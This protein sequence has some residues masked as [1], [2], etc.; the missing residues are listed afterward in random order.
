[1]RAVTSLAHRLT[2]PAVLAFAAGALAAEAPPADPTLPPGALV[3]LGSTRLRP[4]GPVQDLAFSPDGKWLA[5]AGNGRHVQVWDVATGTERRRLA[6][7][8]GPVPGVGLS[9]L[10]LVRFTAGGDTLVVADNLGTVRFLDPVAGTERGRLVSVGAVTDVSLSADGKLAAVVGD[11]AVSLW[12]LPGRTL[13][14]KIPATAGRGRAALTPDGKLLV[15]IGTD[16]SAHVID[17]DTGRQVRTLTPPAD[18]G[19]RFFRPQ[20]LAVA[21]DGGQVALGSWDHQ[22]IVLSLR[23][24]KPVSS[25]QGNAFGVMSLAYA[26]SGRFLAVGTHPG[27]RLYGLASGAE[28]RQL[29]APTPVACN[30]LAFS[31]DGRLLA[32]V[33]QNAVHLWELDSARERFPAE[34]HQGVVSALA[35]LRDGRL[36][37]QGSDARLIAW[38]LAAGRELASTRGLQLPPGE[39]ATTADG[40]GV[41]AFGFDRQ[42][43]VWRPGSPPETRRVSFPAVDHYQLALSPDGRRGACVSA[44]DR[45]LRLFE[46]GGKD[47]TVRVLPLPVG[48]WV[49]R[50]VFS[51]DG[52]RLATQSSDGLLRLWNCETGR[53]L[54]VGVESPGAPRWAARL[55][56]A[57][58]GRRLL[59]QDTE[60]WVAE[61]VSGQR[62]ARLPQP[63][64][65]TTAL[66]F[67]P[68]GRLVAWGGPSGEVRL[69]TADTGEEVAVRQRVGP[70]HDGKPSA[71]PV[72]LHDERQGPVQSVAFSPDGRLLAAGGSS[73]LIVVWKVPAPRTHATIA[74]DRREA[75]WADLGGPDP[76]RAGRAVAELV[77]APGPAVELLGERLRTPAPGVDPKRLER[78]V[79][80]LDNDAFEVREKAQRELA[81]AGAA[82]EGVLRQA[83]EKDPSAELR[84]RVG[85]LLAPLDQGGVPSG[86][87][88]GVRAVEVLERLGTPAARALLEELAGKTGDEVVEQE[89]RDGL[90]RLAARK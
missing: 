42:L 49:N 79:A 32:G 70:A 37:S 59:L 9:A 48:A 77:A 43:H 20:V 73:G 62:R 56:F 76:E 63:A 46:P 41:Q 26:P 23:T 15:L 58:D 74:R 35:F 61:A 34:G 17:C 12:G 86:R 5:T 44:S 21:P 10:S 4:D 66:A 60:L 36:V 83:L 87:L 68:D 25:V 47:G 65:Q 6:L 31:P 51:P 88:R 28:L 16:Q 11:A 18:P 19:R 53:E 54:R 33:A 57:A 67:S 2:L 69:F 80:D 52:S 81:A 27:V 13:R 39:L 22:L 8:G 29:E 90:R 89:V 50:L 24:G 3:R 85:E 71:L 14:H 30:A 55:L 7:D 82:A 78:L 40:G 1:M 45:K 64:A 75:L 38:D 84:R 72:A